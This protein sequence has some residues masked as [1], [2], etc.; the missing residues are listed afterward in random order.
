MPGYLAS[1]ARRC[2]IGT[3]STTVRDR[4][5]RTGQNGTEDKAMPLIDLDEEELNYL[6]KHFI[7]SRQKV[8]PDATST[9]GAKIANICMARQTANKAKAQQGVNPVP[10]YN[11]PLDIPEAQTPAQAHA[12]KVWK[13]LK[14]MT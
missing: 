9:L 14:G 1:R 12:D 2:G 4:G 6:I 5:R 11:D 7:D 10:T 3:N 13:A 8:H